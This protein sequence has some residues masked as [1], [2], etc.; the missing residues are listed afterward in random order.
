MRGKKRLVVHWGKRNFLITPL[1]VQAK[2]VADCSS[3]CVEEGKRGKGLVSQ[4]HPT[5]WLELAA[6]LQPV[7]SLEASQ[8][9]DSAKQAGVKATCSS[10]SWYAIL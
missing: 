7:G 8:D 5:M 3:I 9:G 1:S 6:L 4:T 10:V 2:S